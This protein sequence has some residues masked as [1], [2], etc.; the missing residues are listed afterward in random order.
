MRGSKASA[1]GTGG[2]I[3]LEGNYWG[4]ND[5]PTIRA[6]KIYDHTNNA[7]LPVIDIASPLA[8]APVLVEQ[9]AFQTQPSNVNA[10]SIMNPAV[11]VAVQ[12]QNANVLSANKTTVALSVF[13]GPGVLSGT[14]SLLP[15]TA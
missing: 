7:N 15:S 3:N 11:V 8:T 1:Q 13:S 14:T 6:N 9:L 5:I 12:D 2:P 10:A 4:T